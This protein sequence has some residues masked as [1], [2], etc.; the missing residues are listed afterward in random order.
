MFKN[1][2]TRYSNLVE[3]HHI[4]YPVCMIALGYSV[5]NDVK[6]YGF[7]LIMII[8]GV[9]FA[10]VIITGI[11]WRGPVAYWEQIERTVT[12]MLKINNPDVWHAMGF[13]EIPSTVI[14]QEKRVDSYGQFQGMSIKKTNLEPAIM[15]TLAN[16]VLMSQSL[17]FTEELYGN[18]VK[19][20]RK[21]Q[22]EFK[23]NNW[24][25]PKNSRN[26]RG[27]YMLTKKGLDMMYQYADASIVRLIEKEQ[28][29]EM[30]GTEE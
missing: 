2:F 26:V 5:L 4:L 6:W 20:W 14:V 17:D 21:L 15:N 24:V 3:V 9:L 22:K 12:V 19:N 8:L 13:K 30:S 18:K 29:G 25:T 10:L 28:K 11:A 23:K 7:G 27:G 16:S 1:L